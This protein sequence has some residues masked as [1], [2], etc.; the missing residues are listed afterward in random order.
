MGLN[1]FTVLVKVQYK[2]NLHENDTF[3]IGQ[4]IMNNTEGINANTICFNEPSISKLYK[5]IKEGDATLRTQMLNFK[6]PTKL[7]LHANL[8]LTFFNQ[9]PETIIKYSTISFKILFNCPPI[10]P[11]SQNSR[12]R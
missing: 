10:D 9:H 4:F 11:L 3:T 8:N 1:H 7:F 5:T 2:Y 6:N 12:A